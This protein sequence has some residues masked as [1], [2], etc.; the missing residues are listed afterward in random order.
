[1]VVPA[2]VRV[3]L[4]A[5]SETLAEKIPSEKDADKMHS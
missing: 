1:M 2:Q 5:A 4:K 3:L